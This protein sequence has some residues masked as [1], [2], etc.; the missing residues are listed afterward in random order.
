MHVLFAHPIK[1]ASC[2]L[3]YFKARKLK[4]MGGKVPSFRCNTL[5]CVSPIDW[6]NACYITRFYLYDLHGRYVKCGIFP[7][8]HLKK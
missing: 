3:N 8:F 5:L 7:H 2:T 1:S 4:A 6:H